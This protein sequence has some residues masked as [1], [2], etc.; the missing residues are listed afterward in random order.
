MAASKR[1]PYHN[2]YC[3]CVSL[4]FGSVGTVL[5][6]QERMCR[7]FDYHRDRIGSQERARW[8]YYEW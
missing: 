1:L 4:S 6:N 7:E 8:R 2:Y 5:Y 3:C